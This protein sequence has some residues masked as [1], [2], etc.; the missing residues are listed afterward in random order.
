MNWDNLKYFKQSEFHRPSAQQHYKVDDMDSAFMSKL[1]SAREYCGQ[2]CNANDLPLQPFIITSGN[3][4]VEHNQQV[5]G[6][7]DSTHLFGLAADIEASNSRSRFLIVRSLLLAGFTR[8]EV[9]KDGHIHV[10]S[11]DKKDKGTWVPYVLWLNC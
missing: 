10:D 8:I 2:Y 7:P 6:K 1:E 3:R 9:A 5:G 11:G 4:S